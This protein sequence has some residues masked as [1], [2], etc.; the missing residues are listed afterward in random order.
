M[1]S[2]IGLFDYVE[3]SSP[4]LPGASESKIDSKLDTINTTVQTAVANLD[5]THKNPSNPIKIPSVRPKQSENSE[6]KTVD[7][8]LKKIFWAGLGCWSTYNLIDR[9]LASF[10]VM[11]TLTHGTGPLGYIGINMN[12]ADPNYGGGKTGSSVGGGS[13][14]H[15]LNS[16]K[17]VHVF[18][19][20]EFSLKDTEFP[21]DG[22]KVSPTICNGLLSGGLPRLH[23]VLSGMAN[24]GYSAVNRT[25]DAKDAFLGGIAGLLT[26]TLKFRFTPDE[27][28]NCGDACIFENDPDYSGLAYRTTQALPANR[29][30][31]TGSLTYGVNSGMFN[32]MHTNPQKMLMGVTLLAAGILLGKKTYDYYKSDSEQQSKTTD[33]KEKMSFF[34]KQMHRVSQLHA[35]DKIIVGVLLNTL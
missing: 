1:F 23:A 11:E 6:K 8:K 17:Q 22:C 31:M 2:R 12:G 19:D 32:R 15:I 9:G 24:F 14:F 7:S 10:L 4:V 35:S 27:V 20:T 28:I 29:L 26:P 3:S 25:G 5:E 30:G 21:L 13:E 16:Q 18:K 33:S 34:E